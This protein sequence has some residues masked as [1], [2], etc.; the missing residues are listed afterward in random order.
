MAVS[1][2][3][4]RRASA[5]AAT[6]LQLIRH[7]EVEAGYQK[8]FGGWLDMN[9]S[10]NGRR[11]ARVLADYLRI[12]HLNEDPLPILAKHGVGGCLISP[13]QPLAIYLAASPDWQKVYAD[14]LSVIYIH[15]FSGNK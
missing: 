2:P 10:P 15:T 14:D 6:R 1:S 12:V 11:Q 9:L 13:G 4:R 3:S 5:P 8:K 7:G